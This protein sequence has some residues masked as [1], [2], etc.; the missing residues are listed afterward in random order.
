MRKFGGNPS[1]D[2]TTKGMAGA[3]FEYYNAANMD[4][5]RRYTLVY[6][7]INEL[8]KELRSCSIDEVKEA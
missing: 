2:Q 3:S 5:E 8:H 1:G 4:L 7:L 6:N